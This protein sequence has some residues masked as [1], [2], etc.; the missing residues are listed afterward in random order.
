MT[1]YGSMLA[2]DTE[3]TPIVMK[4]KKP[5]LDVMVKK[6]ERDYRLPF[7]LSEADGEGVFTFDESVDA[8]TFL[9]HLKTATPEDY[10][11]LVAE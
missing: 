10:A 1:S 11:S 6:F 9:R 7:M 8:E 3:Q 5:L 2:Y 4:V